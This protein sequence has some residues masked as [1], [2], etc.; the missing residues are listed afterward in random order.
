MDV[1]G[2]RWANVSYFCFRYSTFVAC[3]RRSYARMFGCSVKDA[4]GGLERIV[5]CAA[6]L[7]RTVSRGISDRRSQGRFAENGKSE[8]GVESEQRRKARPCA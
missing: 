3:L 5:E 1:Q 8:G 6:G 2:E 4:G 7:G